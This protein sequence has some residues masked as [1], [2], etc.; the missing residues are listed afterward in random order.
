[1]LALSEDACTDTDGTSTCLTALDASAPAV[2]SPVKNGTVA[3]IPSRR[4]CALA[5]SEDGNK[6]R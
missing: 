6:P 5:R 4:T 1:M 3:H 2:T